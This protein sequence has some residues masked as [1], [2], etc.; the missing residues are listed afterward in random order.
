MLRQMLGAHD[1]S[2]GKKA[3]RRGPGTKALVCMHYFIVSSTE[4][5]PRLCCP[6]TTC[7]RCP[8]LKISGTFPVLCW[9]LT[10]TAI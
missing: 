9:I 10:D 4:S 5:A 7:N 2:T 6:S 1:C 3:A 8:T